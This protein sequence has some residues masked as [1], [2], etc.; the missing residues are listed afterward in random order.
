MVHHCLVWWMQATRNIA[1]AALAFKRLHGFVHLSTAYVNCNRPCGSHVE[2]RLYRF[3]ADGE[4]DRIASGEACHASSAWELEGVEAL[5]Q[6]LA[7]LPEAAASQRVR[8][9]QHLFQPGP[10]LALRD[11]LTGLLTTGYTHGDERARSDTAG[12]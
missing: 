1:D 12:W 9:T 8:M 2:E 5:A 3:H 6:E 7:A 11:R 10:P 4:A